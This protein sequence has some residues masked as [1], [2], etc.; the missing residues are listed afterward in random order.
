M[1]LSTRRSSSRP[2]VLS[3][4]P[5]SSAG[6]RRR[7]V[8]AWTVGVA[9]LSALVFFLTAL[10]AFPAR[11]AV[12]FQD[13]AHEA[14]IDLVQDPLGA[15]IEGNS[16]ANLN[17]SGVAWVDINHD[18][19]PDL[20]IANGG[21]GS[22]I[23]LNNADGTF[24]DVSDYFRRMPVA[25][26]SGVAV[27]DM[28]N[29][30]LYD[31]ALSNYYHEPCLFAGGPNVFAEKAE[32]LG[33]DPLLFDA[34]N[35]PPGWNGPE[36][37]GVAW[38]DYDNDGY[39]DLYFAQYRLQ[40]DMLLHSAG[41]GYFLRVP[42]KISVLDT[43][44]GFQPVFWDYD[45][46]GDMDIYVANDFGGNFLFENGGS[47]NDWSFTEVA[48]RYK[49]RG[50]GGYPAPSS[51]SMGVA[52]G[53]YDNDLDL[54]IYITNYYEN[55][56]YINTGPYGTGPYG[57]GWRFSRGAADAG[58]QYSLNCWGTDFFDADNDGDLD[59]A[60][61]GGWIPSQ[62]IIDQGR[63]IDNRFYLNDGP[64]DWTFT[65]VTK[66]VGFSDDSVSGRGLATADYDRDGD[67][68]VAMWNCTTVNPTTHEVEQ[69]GPFQ[70]Y[71]NDLTGAEAAHHWAVFELVG[72]GSHG[73]NKGCNLSGVG[74]RV[75]VTTP[76]GTQMREVN[77]GSSFMSQNSLEVEFGLGQD[78][79][80]VEVKVHWTCGAEEI[81][82]HCAADR[83]QKL[84]EGT[85][86]AHAMPAIQAFDANP[87]EEGVELSWTKEP[88]LDVTSLVL[89][90]APDDGSP[91]QDLALEVQWTE[92]RGQALDVDVE[93]GQRY[94]YRL[95]LRGSDGTNGVAELE[96][97]AG[98][99]VSVPS[100]P[101]LGQNFPN[102][103]GSSGAG[104]AKAS[105]P[106]TTIL[107]ELP[108]PMQARLV[109]YDTRGRLVRVVA[110]RFYE[111]AGAQTETWDGTDSSGRR[112]AGGSYRY[113]LETAMG[114]E[115]RGLTLIR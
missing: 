83:Y 70:L 78:T 27:G 68:D 41:G 95:A 16:Q 47:A 93:T 4:R 91:L 90:R 101:T 87:T 108:Q 75:Y 5:P 84:V 112:V 64:P 110:D 92:H 12:Y 21:S 10:A 48:A 86:E 107:F 11:A 9:P 51:M 63:N 61:A 37:T 80:L 52:V 79:E 66:A 6:P 99:P 7:T 19:W 88:W 98:P 28:D 17:G 34:G 15:V 30:G 45:N 50:G 40:P 24:A 58:I 82:T 74:S 114:T 76:S 81:F 113:V 69:P 3:P 77:A 32:T 8:A 35:D 49:I 22:S 62:P 43:A 42:D 23:F 55:E 102:P 94:V 25:A 26:S 97:T 109:I 13:V 44:W 57:T 14:G 106:G 72:G 65:N 36:S 71:R 38:G 54:D 105:G 103:F 111:Q 73:F 31:I 33:L 67:L 53:D 46:D 96:V 2:Q 18:G 115:S 20:V 1:D 39:L 89:Q 59:L 56:L 85:G 60:V 29:D 100:R 104:A